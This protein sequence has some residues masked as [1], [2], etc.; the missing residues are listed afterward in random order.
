MYGQY[1]TCVPVLQWH[2]MLFLGFVGVCCLFICRSPLEACSKAN[3]TILSLKAAHVHVRSVWLA[4]LES[5]LASFADVAE[6]T[7]ERR[8]L[9]VDTT[10]VFTCL[11]IHLE[12]RN[13]IRSALLKVSQHVRMHGTTSACTS[14]TVYLGKIRFFFFVLTCGD[15]SKRTAEPRPRLFPCFPPCLGQACVVKGVPPGKILETN[16]TIPGVTIGNL[17]Y[18]DRGLRCAITVV[19]DWPRPVVVNTDDE[20]ERPCV[21]S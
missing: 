9:N 19:I 17:V 5:M 18:C 1:L 6:L 3:A 8:T 14:P 2:P 4:H 16:G 13:M 15:A 20:R 11:W 12:L 10:W 7:N 21:S